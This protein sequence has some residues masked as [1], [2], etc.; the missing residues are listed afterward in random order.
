MIN[1]RYADIISALDEGR[2]TAAMTSVVTYQDGSTQRHEIVLRVQEVDDRPADD[3]A[4]RP[5]WA[6]TA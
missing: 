3:S 2:S 5:V 6:G 4:A 1:E